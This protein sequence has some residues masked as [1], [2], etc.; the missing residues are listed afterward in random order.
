MNFTETSLEKVRI[1]IH[2]APNVQRGSCLLIR[3]HI[4]WIAMREN[5]TATTSP[6]LNANQAKTGTNKFFD[7]ELLPTWCFL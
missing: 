1:R 6:V 3:G 7:L 5:I 4:A 2:H